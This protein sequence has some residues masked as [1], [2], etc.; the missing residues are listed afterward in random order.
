MP[1]D[2]AAPD[3]SN[4]K[5][6]IPY[7]VWYFSLCGLFDLFVYCFLLVVG[8]PAAQRLET[9]I[10]DF[11]LPLMVGMQ[12]LSFALLGVALIVLRKSASELTNIK[13]PLVINAILFILI[14]CLP[15]ILFSDT[16]NSDHAFGMA[17]LP[18][19]FYPI[20]NIARLFALFCF[21][22]VKR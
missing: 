13:R 5:K 20:F 21:S 19:F 16:E 18:I 15:L 4:S 7:Q 11:F 10:D 9:L 6:E 12:G 14:G 8:L 17:L 2:N 1:K 3:K 22:L